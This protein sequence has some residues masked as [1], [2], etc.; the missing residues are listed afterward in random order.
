MDRLLSKLLPGID[1]NQQVDRMDSVPSPQTEPQRLPRN[2]DDSFDTMVTMQLSR[3]TLNPTQ[4]RFFGKSRFDC[5]LF[6]Y[7]FL[8]LYSV[9]TSWCKPLLI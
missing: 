6:L 9:G 5:S 8:T 1:V 3:L 2:D 7:F 4:N